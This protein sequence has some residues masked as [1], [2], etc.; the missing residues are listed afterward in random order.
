MHLKGHQGQ[1]KDFVLSGI[2]MVVFS[3]EG[4][5]GQLALYTLSEGH[6]GHCPKYEGHGLLGLCL[7]PALHVQVNYDPM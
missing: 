5:R 1:T 4:Y 3:Q 2:C 7:F 6:Q